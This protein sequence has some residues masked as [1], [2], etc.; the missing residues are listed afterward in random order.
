MR[1]DNFRFSRTSV[2]SVE[3]GSVGPGSVGP[4]SVGPGG[5]EREKKNGEEQLEQLQLGEARSGGV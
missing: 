2:G 4:G 1:W 5:A 3:P